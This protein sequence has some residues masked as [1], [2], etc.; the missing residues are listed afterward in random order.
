MVTL[1]PEQTRFRQALRDR[2]GDGCQITGCPVMSVIQAC[3]LHRVADGGRDTA[4]NGI[5]LRVDVHVLFDA[6]LI[7]IDP[8]TLRVQV[9]P[10]LANT[11][12][13]DL[14]GLPLRVGDD[15][16]DPRDLRHRWEAYNATLSR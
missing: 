14:D 5:L 9:N 2:Y 10:A 4:D 6:D 13:A 12:Y 15:R 7:G 3:H 8:E 11:E 1:R 16:P